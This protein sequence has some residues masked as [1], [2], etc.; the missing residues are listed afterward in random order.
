M[1]EKRKTGVSHRQELPIKVSKEAIKLLEYID[2]IGV[3]RGSFNLLKSSESRLKV[4]TP[5]LFKIS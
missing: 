4:Q 2:S 3:T 5:Q 1:K